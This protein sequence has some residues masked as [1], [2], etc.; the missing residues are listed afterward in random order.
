VGQQQFEGLAAARQLLLLL[1]GVSCQLQLCLCGLL[2]ASRRL[3]ASPA[4]RLLCSGGLP[5]AASA[6]C[7]RCSARIR[8]GG[9]AQLSCTLHKPALCCLRRA[10][11]QPRG[12]VCAEVWPRAT[13][14]CHR[15]RLLPL[16][17]RPPAALLACH[18]W[19]AAAGGGAA[20]AEVGQR[21]GRL[22][23]LGKQAAIKQPEL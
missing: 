6:W 2:Q 13:A 22:A 18:A 17:A 5:V 20:A 1:L 7:C 21:E 12:R 4:C 8:L 9:S 14:L 19:R 11:K 10:A 16:A 3:A 15:R 23:L